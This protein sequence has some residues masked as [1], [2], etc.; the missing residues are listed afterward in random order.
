VATAPDELTILDIPIHNV[1]MTEAIDTLRRFLDEPV[2][3][4]VCFVNADVANKAYRDREY[5][6]TLQQAA[7]SLAD[8]IGL[9]LA[10]KLLGRDIKQNVNRTDLF[11]QLCEALEGSGHGIYLLGAKPGVPELVRDRMLER[12]PGLRISGTQHGYFNE[13]EEPGVIDRIA[14]SGASLLLVAF[15]AP[16]QDLWIRTHLEATGV[17]VGIGVGGLFDFYS[18]RMARS[19]QWM[20]E[21]GMEWLYRLYQ[22]PGRMWKRYGIGNALFLYR[23]IKEKYLGGVPS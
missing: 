15:G 23:V 10:G 3:R 1:T 14:R 17:R 18:G 9:K 20:R 16:R 22:E 6:Q 11:P 13:E 2:P 12:F 8:G 7:F 21:M 4:Q 5:R 19:P